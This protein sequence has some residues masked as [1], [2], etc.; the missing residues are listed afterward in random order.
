GE[1]M[2]QWKYGQTALKHSAMTHPLSDAL[3]T[4]FKAGL[5][6]GPLPRGGNGYT[7]G[8]TGNNYR[9][10]SGAS[11]RV[12]IPVG[13]WDKALGMNSPGQSGHPESRYYSNLFELW[14]QDE[15]F[16]MYYSRDSILKYS[17]SRQ[18]LQPE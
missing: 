3:A 17:D 13:D 14:A 10:S 11:F 12:I 5:D 4:E 9:Q 1:D 6:L 15:Y 8:S 16:P 7:P 18:L 2:A